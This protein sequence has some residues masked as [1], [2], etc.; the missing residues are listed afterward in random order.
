MRWATEDPNPQVM[1]TIK[2]KTE[3][4]MIRKIKAKFP[5]LGEDGDILDYEAKYD[6]VP[7]NRSTKK[8]NKENLA[9]GNDKSEWELYCEAYY[10]E[11][12]KYPEGEQGEENE[13]VGLTSGSSAYA[14][15]TTK[16]LAKKANLVAYASSDED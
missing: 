8:E 10:E 13:K 4:E 3:E 16:P 14:V 7:V 11:N 12:A 15:K 2:R 5:K 6:L 1:E 9:F